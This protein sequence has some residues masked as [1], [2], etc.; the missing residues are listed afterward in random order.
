MEAFLPPVVA[1]GALRAPDV[2]ALLSATLP[3]ILLTAGLLVI[4]L[5]ESFLGPRKTLYARISFATV[6][7]VLA[8]TGAGFAGKE[9]ETVAAGPLVVDNMARLF[10][11]FFLACG[12]LTLLFGMRRAR[13]WFSQ[14]EFHVLLLG[15]LAG[16]SVLSAATDV[17]T[18][19]L[20][21]ETVSYTGYLLVGYDKTDR[22]SG[23]A[24][25]KYVVF[26]AA[27][28]GAML[29][30][31]S[32]LFGLSGTTS[33]EG[34]AEAL[35]V[36]G[37]S[38][39]AVMG[40]VLVFAGVAFKVSAV[41]FHFWAPD[42]YAGTST[43]VAG[44]L[45]T[46]SK[47]AGFAVAIRFLGSWTGGADPVAE[48]VSAAFLPSGPL[49]FW[50]LGAAAVATMIVGNTA[51]LRQMEL[52]RLLAW[53]SVAH[54]G[55]LLMAL[56]TG[57]G[58]AYGGIL[59]YFWVYMLMTL[60]GFG[61]VGLLIP[62]LGG[63]EIARYAG[64]AKRN[65]WLA[66]CLTVLMVSLTGL[67]PTAGFWAKVLL[68]MPVVEGKFYGLAIVGL[69]TSAVSLFYYASLIRAMYLMPPAEGADGPVN[70][71]LPDWCLVGV[72]SGLLLL[73]G[74]GFMGWIAD[75]FLKAASDWVP[76]AL[77]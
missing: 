32:L 53:S 16:M 28:S 73:G 44:F 9:A 1:S 72:T 42:A 41:P 56:S 33:M 11:F 49:P 20:A 5:L 51:A 64:L 71:E 17:L 24:G 60:G 65:P 43:A 74:L 62:H 18:A 66:A 22:R 30:G 45:A 8:L 50:I 35:R 14:G 55:Y 25:V 23:E 40:A 68:F 31:L 3:E 26:G 6:L 70:L 34:I 59:V 36:A 13:P 38:P 61:I 19:Y 48:G 69:L 27:A 4:L 2:G 58:E 46:A 37:P 52:K 54:A 57:T 63:T 77:R 39:A 75:G 67:P 7:A 21:F 10:R 76:V 29:F 15:S 12:A 47:A